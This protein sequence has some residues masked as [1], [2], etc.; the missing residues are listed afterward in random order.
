MRPPAPRRAR[1]ALL[2]LVA[3]LLIGACTPSE[4]Q[5]G[6]YITFDADTCAFTIN[7]RMSFWGDG[8]DEAQVTRWTKAINDFWNGKDMRWVTARYASTPPAT[9]LGTT[10]IARAATTVWRSS[11]SRRGRSTPPP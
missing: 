1:L 6:T 9:W 10:T 3:A 7:L 2:T 4:E 11:A 5:G 8:A